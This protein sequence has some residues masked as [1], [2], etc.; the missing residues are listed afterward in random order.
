VVFDLKHNK[1]AGPDGLPAE[2]YQTFREVIKY[3]LKEMFDALIFI[4][5]D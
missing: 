2:F 4:R 1:A 5:G 3:D